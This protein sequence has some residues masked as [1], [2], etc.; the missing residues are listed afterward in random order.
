[1]KCKRNIN[2]GIVGNKSNINFLYGNGNTVVVK[3]FCNIGG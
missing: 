2:P 1:M 3:L